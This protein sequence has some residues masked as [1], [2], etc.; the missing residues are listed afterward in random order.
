MT[1]KQRF[2]TSL[3]LKK[4]DDVVSYMELEFHLY[5][6]FV[7]KE[8]V[9][10]YEFSKLSP[11]EQ[12]KAQYRN[13][14]IMLETAEKAGHDA[15]KDIGGF[16][17]ISPGKPAY[18]WLPDEKSRLNHIKA[19]KKVAGDK[20]FIIGSVGATMS[21]PDGNHIYDFVMDLYDNPEEVKAKN[22]KQL[23]DALELQNKLLEAGADGIMNPSDVAFNNGPFIS[24][25][26]MDEFFF[27][28]F[29]RWVED[30]KK[31]FHRTKNCNGNQV[32]LL[33]Y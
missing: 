26:R 33:M 10:G 2:T 20:Y 31:R 22:E 21:I 6:E 19:L 28:Y 25:E 4:P 30:L 32:N 1:P 5:Q 16:W 13:A 23:L 12:E 7:G 14:E 9:I 8:P 24:P 29:N 11:A 17:E 18:L 15:I 3:N 27:P